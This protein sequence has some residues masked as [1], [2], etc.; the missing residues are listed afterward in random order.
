[1]AFDHDSILKPLRPCAAELGALRAGADGP[2]RSRAVVRVA[3][4]AE[5]VLRRFLRDDPTAPVELRL[6]ALA[7]EDLGSDELLAE[8]RRRNRLPMELAAA[9]HELDGTRR[10]VAGGGE[11]TPRDA[12]LALNVAEGLDRHVMSIPAGAPLADPVK[13]PEETLLAPIGA[14]PDDAKPVRPVPP[15]SWSRSLRL[16]GGALAVVALLALGWAGWRAAQRDDDLERGEEYLRAG[17]VTAAAEV[18]EEYAQ[19]HP[20]EIQPR[21]YLGRIYRET[22]RYAD[23]GRELRRGLRDA[24]EDPRLHTE[25][26][27]L[28]LE[29]GR[30]GDAARTFRTALDRDAEATTAWVGLVRALRVNGNEAAAQRALAGAPDEVRA[31]LARAEPPAPAVPAAAPGAAQPLPA[32]A[33]G[34][35]VP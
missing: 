13:E 6:R 8:L 12:E 5:E 32:P 4:A 16:A 2:E 35:P 28:L 7:P 31:L 24:P 25:L 10:R 23:A 27:Y 3:T 22:G 29:T 26:G 19:R 17:R 14:D 1:M 33:A 15:A 30:P 20:D 34:V 21:L 18:F 9:F 11:A